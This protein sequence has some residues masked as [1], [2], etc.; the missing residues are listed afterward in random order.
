[1]CTCWCSSVYYCAFSYDFNNKIKYALLTYDS[2]I[3]NRKVRCSVANMQS[4]FAYNWS[5]DGSSCT[6]Q[7]KY[8]WTYFGAPCFSSSVVG[9]TMCVPSFAYSTA[10]SLRS[11]LFILRLITTSEVSRI[12]VCMDGVKPAISVRC[13]SV[14]APT[15]ISFMQFMCT[16]ITKPL[17]TWN[18]AATDVLNSWITFNP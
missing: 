15:V 11:N 18:W 17:I 5:D 13:N 8:T 9:T 10:I 3:V 6:D 2:S 1:M 4:Q 14:N 7:S 16:A 12:I